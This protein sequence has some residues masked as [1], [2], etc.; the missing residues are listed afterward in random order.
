MRQMFHRCARRHNQQNDMH[1][2]NTQLTALICDAQHNNIQHKQHSVSSAVMISVS[3]YAECR[4]SFIVMLSVIMPSV[5][6]L[7]V[8]FHLMLCS[9]SLMSVIMLIVL[10]QC[11]TTELPLCHFMT[12]CHWLYKHREIKHAMPGHCLH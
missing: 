6:V 3:G 5:I 10:A 9:V 8:T 11:D 2:N 4:I 7:S 12:H 1:R